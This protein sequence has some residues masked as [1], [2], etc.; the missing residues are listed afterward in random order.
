MNEKNNNKKTKKEYC[1]EII[2]TAQQKG[3]EKNIYRSTSIL[4]T[5]RAGSFDAIVPSCW[6]ASLHGFIIDA[7]NV[8]RLRRKTSVPRKTDSLL[9]RPSA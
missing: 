3:G 2:T 6:I 5:R 7:E 1:Q 8:T 9:S 4:I